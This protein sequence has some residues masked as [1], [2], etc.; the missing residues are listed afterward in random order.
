MR[1][2]DIFNL[3]YDKFKFDKNKPIRLFELKNQ[4]NARLKTQML[5]FLHH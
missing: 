3:L 4:K 1:Q 2:I 5:D